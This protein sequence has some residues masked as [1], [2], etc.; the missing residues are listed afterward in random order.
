MLGAVTS[1]ADRAPVAA[2]WRR[3]LVVLLAVAAALVAVR[4]PMCTDGMLTHTPSMAMAIAGSVSTPMAMGGPQADGSAV[5]PSRWCP[6]L[7]TATGRSTT[8][9]E[10][11]LRASPTTVANLTGA[12]MPGAARDLWHAPVPAAAPPLPVIAVL[13]HAATLHQ[14]GL[15]RR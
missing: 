13:R 7:A 5:P 11:C 15:L 9:P 1:L 6:A 12:I 8:D 2:A 14:L 3:R 10:S 4:G